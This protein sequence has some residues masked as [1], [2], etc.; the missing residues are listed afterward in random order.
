MQLASVPKLL[1]CSEGS[2]EVAF[3][4]PLGDSYAEFSDD[5]RCILTRVPSRVVS[6][7]AC[8]TTRVWAMSSEPTCRPSPM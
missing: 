2:L 6:S 1:T 3:V 7:F 4:S 8:P 5:A